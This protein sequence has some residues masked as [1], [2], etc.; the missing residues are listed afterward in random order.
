G[1]FGKDVF[2][3]GLTRRLDP[4]DR[5]YELGDASVPF[6]FD[7]HMVITSEDAPAL[8]RALHKAFHKRRVNKVNPGR[9]SSGCRSRRS[10][11]RSGSTTGVGYK[12]DAEALEYLQSQAM[13]DENLEEVEEAFEEAEEAVAA[14][15]VE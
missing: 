2:K 8:E 3:I 7:V 5:V 1:S 4:M 6:P 14:S 13:T 10:S 9:S 11:G 12:A 15:P